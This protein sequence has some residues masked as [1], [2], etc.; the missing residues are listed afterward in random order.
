MPSPEKRNPTTQHLINLWFD[1]EDVVFSLLIK[2]TPNI[3]NSLLHAQ[4]G[5]LQS[6]ES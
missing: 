2:Q 6:P 4:I 5:E 1:P 3:Q